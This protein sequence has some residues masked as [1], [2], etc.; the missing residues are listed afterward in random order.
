MGFPFD[1]N[2]RY[3]GQNYQEKKKKLRPEKKIKRFLK[4]IYSIRHLRREE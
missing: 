2:I 1:G 4:G 3:K